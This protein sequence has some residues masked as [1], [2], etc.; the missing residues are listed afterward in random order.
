MEKVKLICPVCGTGNP[1]EGRFCEKCGAD[2]RRELPAI[3]ETAP[4]VTWRRIGTTLALGAAALALELGL[5]L[6]RRRLQKPS[7]PS[8][9][10]PL[11]EAV[12]RLFRQETSPRQRE[13]A[14]EFCFYWERVV[15]SHRHGGRFWDAE[16]FS[17]LVREIKRR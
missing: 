17:L 5:E 15:E 16:R 14:K 13:Q 1:L 11:L 2:M 7:P 3:P 10:F 8:R 9:R 12:R 6:L 4:L